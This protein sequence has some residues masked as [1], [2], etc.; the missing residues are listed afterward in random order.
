[1]ATQKMMK[2]TMKTT[3]KTMTTKMMTMMTVTM[4]T[5]AKHQTECTQMKNETMKSPIQQELHWQD[6]ENA[7]NAT[8]IWDKQSEN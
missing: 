2:K 1:M 6:S 4:T 7:E 8:E 3:L 5:I